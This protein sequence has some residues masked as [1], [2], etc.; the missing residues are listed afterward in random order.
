MIQNN[1]SKRKGLVPVC[2]ATVSQLS[3]LF[4]WMMDKWQNSHWF[5]GEQKLTRNEQLS[6]TSNILRTQVLI[7]EERST[8]M[9]KVMACG[10]IAGWNAD[11]HSEGLICLTPHTD[12]S[13]SQGLAGVQAN[14][15]KKSRQRLERPPHWCEI[16]C[17]Y[18]LS[19]TVCTYVFR[20]I[21]R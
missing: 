10:R 18:N 19:H 16:V 4:I 14:A 8:Q 11:P 5:Q 13:K 9:G 2:M 6:C 20:R 15:S 12:F 17:T 7:C 1:Q 3:Y 21:K